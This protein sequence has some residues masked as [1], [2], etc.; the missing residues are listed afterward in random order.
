MSTIL[1]Q[2]I[3]QLNRGS[4]PSAPRLVEDSVMLRVCVQALVSVGILATDMAA[5]LGNGLW[6]LSLIHI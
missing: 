2:K 4:I 1:R 5:S 3:Q 6:A